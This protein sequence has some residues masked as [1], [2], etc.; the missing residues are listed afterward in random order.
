VDNWKEDDL[1]KH[2]Y[3]PTADGRRW[4]QKPKAAAVSTPDDSGAVPKPKRCVRRKTQ[5]PDGVEKSRKGKGGTGVK[6]RIVVT[7]YRNRHC[8]PDNL[9][10]KYYIDEIE[11]AGLIPDDSSEYI[12]EVVK[13]VRVIKGEPKTVIEVI[14]EV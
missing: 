6:F 10:P 9:C 1:R 11:R 14:R 13:R 3:E 4:R 12:T 8:D 2:G 7:S 5:G